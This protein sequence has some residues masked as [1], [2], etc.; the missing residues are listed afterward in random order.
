[1]TDHD[2]PYV[3]ETGCC[4]TGCRFINSPGEAKAAG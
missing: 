1:L 4:S 3:K 2:E